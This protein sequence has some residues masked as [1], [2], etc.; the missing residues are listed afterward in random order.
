[1]SNEYDIIKQENTIVSL[2][3]Q[4]ENDLLSKNHKELILEKHKKIKARAKNLVLST[5]ISDCFIILMTIISKI[6]H[7][8]F[9]VLIIRVVSKKAYGI[10]S[11]YL[12]FIHDIIISF[13]SQVIRISAS[14]YSHDQSP[15]IE[16]KNFINS[17]KLSWLINFIIIPVSILLY[18]IFVLMDPTLVNYKYHIILYI[19]SGIIENSVEPVMIYINVKV[20]NSIKTFILFFNDILNLFT[21]YILCY[22]FNLDLWAFTLS[23][24]I[25]SIFYCTLLFYLALS[26]NIDIWLLIPSPKLLKKRIQFYY[27]IIKKED[28]ELISL[29]KLEIRAWSTDLLLK[30]IERIVLSFFVTYSD[31]IKAEYLFVKGNFEFFID[32]FIS[33]TGENFFILLNKIKNFNN[34]TTLRSGIEI[35][36][37][38]DFSFNDN[39]YIIKN[40]STKN[41]AVKKESYPYK[42][43]KTHIKLYLITGILMFCVFSIL[44]KNFL[45]WLFTDKWANETT[46]SLMKLFVLSISLNLIETTFISYSAAIYNSFNRK[47]IKGFGRANNFLLIA[48]S[49]SL[50]QIN[51]KGLVYANIIKSSINILL[52]WYFT[53]RNEFWDIENKYIERFIFKE[54]ISFAKDSSMKNNSLFYTF[55]SGI[56]SYALNQLMIYNYFKGLQDVVILFVDIII[57]TNAFVIIYLE[58][59]QFSEILKLKVPN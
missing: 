19:F 22:K 23:R 17:S 6:I 42:L 16:K 52:N 37:K 33:P 36:E 25:T 58:K 1:M 26:Y 3:I 15:V 56:S 21:C 27:N 9:T 44:G 40:L 57:A 49:F 11:V 50:I 45:L 48:L 18:Y 43:L 47:L 24:L 59:D 31:D 4:S 32:R 12:S 51:I 35:T 2:D 34:I 46:F 8:I 53:V 28:S 13:P 5:V 39:Q 55:F 14:C 41:S 10:E 20:I 54:M 30:S 29:I 38:G 7:V